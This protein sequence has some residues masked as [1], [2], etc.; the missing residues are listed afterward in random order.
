MLVYSEITE[1]A[2]AHDRTDLISSV[3][4]YGGSLIQKIGQKGIDFS[5]P[6]LRAIELQNEFDPGNITSN[7]K[8]LAA[9]SPAKPGR[10]VEVTK[11]PSRQGLPA[12]PAKA[13]E[14]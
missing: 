5:Q 3:R 6:G 4:T 10:P 7:A 8:P 14:D 9:D 2:V 11:Q 13:H 1:W 12:L